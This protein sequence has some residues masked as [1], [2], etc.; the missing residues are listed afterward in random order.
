M[1]SGAVHTNNRPDGQVTGQDVFVHELIS[2]F[3]EPKFGE[4]PQM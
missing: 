1:P 3:D 4:P 2:M